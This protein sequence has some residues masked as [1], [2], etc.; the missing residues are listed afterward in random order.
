[1]EKTLTLDPWH[2]HNTCEHIPNAETLAAF[3]ETEEIINKIRTG[4][5]VPT[6]SSFE[7]MVIEIYSELEAEGNEQEIQSRTLYKV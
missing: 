5:Y 4:E 7:E 6:Y 2:A 1:M 3:A